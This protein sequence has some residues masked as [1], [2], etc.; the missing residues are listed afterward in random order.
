[1]SIS[2]YGSYLNWAG[3]ENRS[4]LKNKT[5]AVG[6]PEPGHS[7][8]AFQKPLVVLGTHGQVWGLVLPAV[9]GFY[10]APHLSSTSG[11]PAR[12]SWHRL[13]GSPRLG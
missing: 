8:S 6:R 13:A 4:V 1:M 5:D 11:G 2:Q 12:F 3:H 9:R 7:G 10:P